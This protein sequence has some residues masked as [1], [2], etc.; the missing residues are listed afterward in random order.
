MEFKNFIYVKKQQ[1][2]RYLAL[3]LSRN[4]AFTALQLVIKTLRSNHYLPKNIIALEVFGFIGTSTALDY[5][6]LTDYLE[7]WELDPYFAKK[8]QK[9]NPRAKVMCGDS[10]EALAQGK[11]L[12]RDYNF[13]VIDANI[14]SA[15]DSSCYE[16]FGVFENSLNYLANEAIVIV[17]IYNNLE[18]FAAN[19][20]TTTDKLDPAWLKARKSFYQ[21][22]NVLTE[23]GINYLPAFEKILERKNFK[24]IYNNFISRNDSV[25]FG[26]FVVN[27][28]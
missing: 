11:V 5:A 28:K 20:N 6:D 15:S 21:I 22:D 24:V 18:A 23:K 13:I 10:M 19:Y 25:G 9:L 16:S 8:A 1:L 12:R 2:S 17:T 7:M 14:S 3:K 26:V 4:R 27:K